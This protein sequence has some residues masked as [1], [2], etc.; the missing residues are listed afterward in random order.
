[1]LALWLLVP[2][3]ESVDNG[4]FGLANYLTQSFV[5]SR[6]YDNASHVPIGSEYLDD[7][8][9]DGLSDLDAA[10]A[11]YYYLDQR[12]N[13]SINNWQIRHTGASIATGQVTST[14]PVPFP[15]TEP[16]GSGQLMAWDSDNNRLIAGGPLNPGGNNS[17]GIGY[18][19]PNTCAWNQIAVFDLPS[20]LSNQGAVAYCP[21]SKTLFMELGD[22]SLQ[23]WSVNMV[24]GAVASKALPD[25]CNGLQTLDYDPVTG[26]LYGIGLIPHGGQNVSRAIVSLDCVSQDVSIVGA[27]PGYTTQ[28]GAVATLDVASRGLYWIGQEANASD[29]DPF[30]LIKNSI[31]DGSVLSVSDSLICQ[32]QRAPKFVPC[33]W[34]L[35]YYN[36]P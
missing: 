27:V 8:V 24:T 10:T 7:L 4:L 11:T 9:T 1:M 33:P 34:S 18:I 35:Q 25:Q 2:V 32:F 20:V 15:E 36:S 31:V 19:D 14:C 22:E 21:T 16:I 12:W 3:A 30:Y 6:F 26:K 28:Y 17:Y 23:L 29:Y 5:L 13:T